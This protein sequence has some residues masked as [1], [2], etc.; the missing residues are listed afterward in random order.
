MELTLLYVALPFKHRRK[1]PITLLPAMVQD[2]CAECGKPVL[3]HRRMLRKAR[4][5]CARRRI[6]LRILC[7]PCA[8]SASK[9]FDIAAVIE[10]DTSAIAHH[11]RRG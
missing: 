4:S 8:K 10:P 11:F 1:V 9:K 7:K 2:Q 6:I 3:V 5:D